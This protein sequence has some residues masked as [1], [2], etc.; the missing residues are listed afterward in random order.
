MRGKV[1]LP[2]AVLQT[3][4]E[5]GPQAPPGGAAWGVDFSYSLHLEQ[6]VHPVNALNP[7]VLVKVHN[8][9]IQNV[10]AFSVGLGKKGTAKMGKSASW[11]SIFQV[12]AGGIPSGQWIYAQ[13][14]LPPGI[15]EATNLVVAVDINEELEENNESNNYSQPFRVT[16]VE[17]AKPSLPAQTADL[18]VFP[19]TT[20]GVYYGD[21]QGVSVLVKNMGRSDSPPCTI[22]IGFHDQVQ[23]GG[24]IKWVGKATVPKIFSQQ[25]VYVTVP[26]HF[27]VLPADSIY[28]VAVD[29][30]DKVDEQGGEDNNL[31]KP[32]TYNFISGSQAT[33]PPQG[34]PFEAFDIQQPKSGKHLQ[35]GSDLTVRWY[36]TAALNKLSADAQSSYWKIDISLVDPATGK[37]VALLAKNAT[38]QPVSGLHTWTVTLPESIGDYQLRFS[39]RPGRRLG[40]ERHLQ[41][42]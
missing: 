37:I 5:G 30:D 31:S 26:G 24:M 6:G 20:N 36:P 17:P 13:L 19:E 8:N 15:D 23:K 34:Q 22:G 25:H 10:P 33:L 42:V 35:A 2:K 41:L 11:L 16:F 38:N 7:M 14:K 40:R 28:T 39:S 1:L 9:G 21:G 3:G 18:M 12:P 4:Q 27:Q 29:I 32:F